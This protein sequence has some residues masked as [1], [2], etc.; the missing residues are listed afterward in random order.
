MAVV[1]LPPAII[2]SGARQDFKTGY[3]HIGPFEFSSPSRLYIVLRQ[4]D[5]GTGWLDVYKS[6]DG[7][8]TSTA[9]DHANRPLNTRFYAAAQQGNNIC[10]V[11]SDGTAPTANPLRFQIFDASTD[12]WGAVVSGG[13]TPTG[14]GDNFY[15]MASSTGVFYVVYM[16]RVSGTQFFLAVTPISGGAWGVQ[17]AI[18]TSTPN[19]LDRI[20][21][22]QIDPNDTIHVIYAH[23][24]L[25]VSNAIK[26]LMVATPGLTTSEVDVE[27]PSSNTFSALLP[28]VPAIWGNDIA[29]PYFTVVAGQN[30]PAVWVGTNYAA[31][32]YGVLTPVLTTPVCTLGGDDAAEYYAVAIGGTLYVFFIVL[33]YSDPLNVI[34]QMWF[35]SN[36]GSGWDDSNA[37][38]FYDAVTNPQLEDPAEDPNDQF[39]HTISITSLTSG[40]FGVYTA[41]EENGECSGYYLLNSTSS[42]TI[43]FDPPELAGVVVMPQVDNAHYNENL[44]AFEVGGET[45]EYTV[46]GGTIPDGLSLA[47]PGSPMM[48][49]QT[50]PITSSTGIQIQGQPT[51]S[52]YQGEVTTTWGLNVRLVA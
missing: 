33:D 15:V 11:W 5:F 31:P 39:L 45:F 18:T 52:E 25:L 27:N 12:T 14:A 6:T 28:S 30:M 8:A 29:I 41:M 26:D 21:N 47:P 13:P 3:D 1:T 42:C 16:V 9:Q 10:V 50:G 44:I 19:V 43:L 24:V 32:T 38:L 22:V 34:D 51:Y 4:S 20:G 2:S 46:T 37:Q 36:N 7:G 49:T 48:T 35:V 40:T 17:T 23:N